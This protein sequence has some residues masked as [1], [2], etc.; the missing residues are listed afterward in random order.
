MSNIIQ[1][2]RVNCRS[3]ETQPLH[4]G[5]CLCEPCCSNRRVLATMRERQ[6]PLVTDENAE[7]VRKYENSLIQGLQN[8]AKNPLQH[9]GDAVTEQLI[10]DG[11]IRT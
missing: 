9:M 4:V 11:I 7:T 6:S 2:P 10:A 1:F 8:W 5:N 3:E